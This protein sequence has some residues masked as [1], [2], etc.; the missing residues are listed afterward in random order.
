VT[1]ERFFHGPMN[2]VATDHDR[3]VPTWFAHVDEDIRA[4]KTL[5][6]TTDCAEGAQL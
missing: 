6:R 3:R 4:W 1:H 5:S 2:S